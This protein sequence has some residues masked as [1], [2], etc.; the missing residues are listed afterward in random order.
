MADE[1]RHYWLAW[2]KAAAV[3][4]LR[5]FAQT[6]AATLATATTLTDAPWGVALGTAG[7][8]ALLSMLT[9]LGGLPEVGEMRQMELFDESEVADD[10]D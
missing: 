3:R 7:L 6:L 4:A 10:A 8:A 2:L 9:S 5:T 1:T